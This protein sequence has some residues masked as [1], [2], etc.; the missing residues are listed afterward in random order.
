MLVQRLLSF[1]KNKLT[2]SFY[3]EFWR[4][5]Q[6]IWVK[7]NSKKSD[8][9]SLSCTS[10]TWL[11]V[12]LYSCLRLARN[13]PRFQTD[14]RLILQYRNRLPCLRLRAKICLRRDCALKTTAI[15]TCTLV[16]SR[17]LY[18]RSG[19]SR[20]TR[21]VSNGPSKRYLDM[22]RN[23]IVASVHRPI[24]LGGIDTVSPP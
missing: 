20:E 18:C 2:G 3:C 9:E 10:D 7:R 23:R 14:R 4:Q 6:R 1:K 15:G 24:R 8:K 12:L 13:R 21:F 19:R 22:P 17:Q 16:R 5:M 11:Q